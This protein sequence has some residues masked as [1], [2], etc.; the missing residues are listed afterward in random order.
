MVL[1][2]DGV[3]MNTTIAAAREPILMES[4]IRMAVAAGGESLWGASPVGVTRANLP[5]P[6]ERS[7]DGS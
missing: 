7:S 3:H 2:W 6:M 5:R 4:T 1:G